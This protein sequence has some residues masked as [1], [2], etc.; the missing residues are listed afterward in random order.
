MK[1]GRR[2]AKGSGSISWASN[3]GITVKMNTLENE[4]VGLRRSDGKGVHE[5]FSDMRSK[6]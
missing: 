4:A 6:V 2:L 1:S 3:V 5:E